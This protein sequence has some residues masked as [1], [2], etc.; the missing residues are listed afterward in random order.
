MRSIPACA[1]EPLRPAERLPVAEGLSPRVR[2]NPFMAA[3][4][5]SS[6]GTGLSPRVRGNRDRQVLDQGL[7]LTGLS[8]RVRGNREAFVPSENVLRT[9][10]SPRVRGN[11]ASHASKD[12]SLRVYPRVC[13]GTTEMSCAARGPPVLGLSPRVRGNQ[14]PATLDACN[15]ARSIPACAGEPCHLRVTLRGIPHF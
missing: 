4:L 7:D 14:H 2:G 13:G 3:V 12:S 10:L 11:H 1:G 6:N 5:R 15:I 8:P 9:G